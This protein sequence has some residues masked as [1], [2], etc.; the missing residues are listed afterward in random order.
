MKSYTYILIALLAAPL[1]LSA[2]GNSELPSS[3]P[4]PNVLPVSFKQKQAKVEPPLYVYGGDS[5]RDPFI[6]L[7]IENS[8]SGGGASTEEVVVPRL[9]ALSLKGIID[10]G[11]A[12][13]AL[14]SGGGITYIL[15]EHSLYDN[16]QR[17][18]RGV[19]GAIRKD[20]VVL[21]G[22]DRVTKELKLRK[23]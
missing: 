7:N 13:T 5:R 12:M 9:D 20:S 21:M 11:K 15:R 6:A 18:V 8:S 19:S 10:D 23:K 4:S 1:F 17:L 22:A 14:I 16:R 2:C 3:P